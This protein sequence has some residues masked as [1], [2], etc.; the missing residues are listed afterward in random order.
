MGKMRKRI[1]VTEGELMQLHFEVEQIR[2]AE[3]KEMYQAKYK[4]LLKSAQ[5]VNLHIQKK[6]VHNG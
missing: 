1:L 6:E 3:K 5:L 2:N 4:N